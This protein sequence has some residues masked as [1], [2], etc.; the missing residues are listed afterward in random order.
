MGFLQQL[1]PDPNQLRLDS[2][3]LDRAEQSFT[4]TVTSVQSEAYC[5]VCQTGS[6]RIHSRY[7]R[8]LQDLPC[9][10]YRVTLLVKVR[11]F[12]CPNPN[13]QRRIF[14]ERFSQLTEPWARRTSRLAQHLITIGLAL[15]GKAG[16]RLSQHLSHPVSLNPLL[17][18]LSRLSLPAVVTPKTLG[19]D[20]FAFRKG[21]TYGTL[22]VDLDQNR[23]I[24]LLA[25][26]KA[27]TL[28]QWLQQHSGVEILSRDRSKEYRQGMTQGAPDALQVADRFHL[29]KNLTEVLQQVLSAQGKVLKL[30]QLEPVPE[31]PIERADLENRQQTAYPTLKVQQQS[32]QRRTQRLQT[33]QLIWQLHLQG[34]TT[35]QIAQQAGVSSRTVQRYLQTSSFPARQARS[36][37]G[38]SLVSA[39]QEYLIQQWNQGHRGMRSLF[40]DL[41]QQGYDG[42][43]MSLVRY[44]HQF[45]Q[46]QEQVDAPV[47]PTR[48]KRPLPQRQT[49]TARQASYLIVQNPQTRTAEDEQLLNR[50]IEQNPSLTSAVEFAQAFA[51]LVRQRQPKQ[52]D[53]W[54][55][56]AEVIGIEPFQRF[57]KS[58][59]EDYEAVKAGVTLATSNG[60]VEGQVN[61]LKMLKRQMY[62]RA[63]LDLLSRRFL[64]AS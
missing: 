23:P 44:L 51:Q 6:R 5:P 64:L 14:T 3:A 15:G 53:L 28:A 45:R 47:T 57:A 18:L 42:S 35:A 38:R 36:D 20:D 22:L 49:L 7:Q 9:M 60:Q 61:R 1:L 40:R 52:L 34:D 50:L 43:Y 55:Q 10:N 59:Q 13:C 54:L 11:K 48:P 16:V 39:Y 4:L 32:E 26:R 62:G 21:R 30:A 56:Q 8:T 37:R 25:D 24:A 46:R 19:V 58:L 17:Q 33:Y 63:G 31:V 2:G 27:Q 12:F 41:Q 29:L